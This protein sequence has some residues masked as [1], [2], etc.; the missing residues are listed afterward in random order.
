VLPKFRF[1]QSRIL[2]C[3]SSEIVFVADARVV[4]GEGLSVVAYGKLFS[5]TAFVIS[6]GAS[7]KKREH[8]NGW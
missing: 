1:F 7:R 5:R 2:A 6:S 3:S 8:Q 4:T